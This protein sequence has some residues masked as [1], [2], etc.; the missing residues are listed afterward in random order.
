MPDGRLVNINQNSNADL[1]LNALIMAGNNFFSV[2]IG[3][4]ATGL[5]TDPTTGLVAAG[6]SAGFT[7]FS[8]LAIQRGL[9]KTEAPE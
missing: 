6:I 7:F 4:G 3:L 8:S 9:K 5:L 1:F 2:L